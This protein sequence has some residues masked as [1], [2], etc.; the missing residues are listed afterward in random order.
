MQNF[1]KLFQFRTDIWFHLP[2]FSGASY[3]VF[4]RLI[5]CLATCLAFSVTTQT[6]RDMDH[7]PDSVDAFFLGIV[8]SSRKV[9]SIS[10]SSAHK[11]L[12][13]SRSPP[14]DPKCPHE[15]PEDDAL[16]TGG[17]NKAHLVLRNSRVRRSW[18]LPPPERHYKLSFR[19]LQ[20]IEAKM[21]EC[22]YFQIY[23]LKKVQRT[24]WKILLKA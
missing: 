7:I 20:C 6:E 23:W 22:M 13:A 1:L 8:K 12:P 21:W 2:C 4:I 19:I 15:T 3:K 17:T 5:Y 16:P 10:R 24:Y 9:V 18:F 11:A 14:T